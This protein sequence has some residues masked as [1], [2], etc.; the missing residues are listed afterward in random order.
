MMRH[1]R[2]AGV[3]IRNQ[4]LT[5][6]QAQQ[7]VTMYRSGMTQAQIG[8]RFGVSQKT[9]GHYLRLLGVEMRPPLVKAVP[10]D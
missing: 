5:D 10:S 7:A 6:E 4:G 3:A 1:L 2:E 9:A 8:N